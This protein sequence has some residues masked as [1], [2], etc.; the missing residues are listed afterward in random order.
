LVRKDTN[1][2]RRYLLPPL[3][4]PQDAPAETTRIMGVA[5]ELARIILRLK[6]GDPAEALITRRIIELAKAGER[7][8][9]VLCERVLC[10]VRQARARDGR[11]REPK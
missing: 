3:C 1:G 4:W 2:G 9:D 10:R 5:F 7:N 6:S 8:P 11:P